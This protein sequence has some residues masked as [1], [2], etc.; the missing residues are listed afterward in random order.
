MSIFENKRAVALTGVFALGFAGLMAWGFTQNATAEAL[1]K[2]ATANESTLRSITS[3][4]LTPKKETR[5]TLNT[6]AKTIRSQ[7]AVLKSD[8]RTYTDTCKNITKDAISKEL[9]FHPDHLKAARN[10]INKKAGETGTALPAGDG[11]TFGL[12]RNY[13]ERNDAA[14]AQT[15]PFL[16]Y[17][18]NAARTLAGYVVDAGAVSLDRMYCEPVPSEED[19]EYT[20]LHI[21]LSFTAKRGYIPSDA[22]HTSTIT[23]VLNAIVEGNGEIVTRNEEKKEGKYFFNIKGMNV[24]TNNTYGTVD[25]YTEPFQTAGSDGSEAESISIAQQ[26]AGHEDETAYVNMIIEAVYF[27]QN[28]N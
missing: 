2:E 14:N 22:D 10:W 9:L 7:A 13:N 3:S 18:L 26:K 19:G 17:Q 6:H 24:N 20:R 4:A 8:L 1:I 21:E 25:P 15:T 27:S 16:L 28:A 5:D 23:R 12:D 11:F